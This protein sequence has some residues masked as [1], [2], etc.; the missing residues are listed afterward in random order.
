M[1][2]CLSCLFFASIYDSV[3]DFI[4]ISKVFSGNKQIEDHII[5]LKVH[6]SIA[7]T[8]QRDQKVTISEIT[9]DEV[10][11]NYLQWFHM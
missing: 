1:F 10:F 9:A 5:L 7:K 2:L 4:T 11:F 6:F 3:S 8:P